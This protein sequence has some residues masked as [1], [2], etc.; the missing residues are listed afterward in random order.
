MATETQGTFLVTEA[1]A[2]TAVL[3]DVETAQVYSL[4]ANPGFSV[5]EV[6]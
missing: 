6:V 3:Q 2:E 1:E 4:A 5:D